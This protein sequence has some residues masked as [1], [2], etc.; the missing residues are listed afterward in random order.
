M[1]EAIG[2][3]RRRYTPLRYLL[4]RLTYEE[5]AARGRWAAAVIARSRP[6]VV[7]A[8]S[9]LA[10]ESA[11]WAR[12]HARTIVLE[13]A[14]GHLRH[15]RDVIDH[16]ARR[17]GCPCN[18]WHP[19]TGMIARVDEEFALAN[20]IRV[21]ST[22]ARQSLEQFGVPAAK[23]VHVPQSVDVRRFAP[24]RER[25]PGE[26]LRVCFAGTLCL[27]KGF[28]H[29]LQ[30]VRRLGAKGVSLEFVGATGDPFCR[31]LLARERRGLDVVVRAGDPV[32]AYH[33]ADVFVLP[34]LHDG[35]GLVVA[36]AMACGL[37]VI[38]T[39][40]CGAAEW[41]DPGR[42]GWIVPAG[43]TEA[44]AA[45]LDEAGRRRTDLAM[46]EAARATAVTRAEQ[47]REYGALLEDLPGSLHTR[48]AADA[49]SEYERAGTRSG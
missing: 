34:T 28:V 35:F 33:R 24:P 32:P 22:W 15:F 25:R 5:D 43:D 48:D 16:E 36:E 14:S 30:A 47:P 8:F 45:A 11:R 49:A 18:L 7:V 31:W 13:H 38:T 46:G 27:R 6:D 37:P 19:T 29:L 2:C 23:V 9:Q 3:A 21:S 39:H 10:L 1:P 44:L 20:V 17:L 40:A 12:A 42:T 26:R 41:I 4:G